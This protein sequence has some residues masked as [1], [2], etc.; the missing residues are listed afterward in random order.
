MQRARLIPAQV[1]HGR[2]H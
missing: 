1:A 2:N